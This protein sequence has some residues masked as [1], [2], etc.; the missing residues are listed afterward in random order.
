VR[1]G[2]S[3]F[4][5]EPPPTLGTPP[6]IYPAGYGWT[7]AVTYLVTASVVVLMYPLCRWFARLKATRRAWWLSYL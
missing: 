1:Y 4:L 5:V 2:N 3:P 6:G 7:L